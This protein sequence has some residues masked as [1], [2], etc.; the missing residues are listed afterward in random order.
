PRNP[1][2][3]ARQRRESPPSAR[4]VLPPPRTYKLLRRAVRPGGRRPPIPGLS[5]SF[6]TRTGSLENAATSRSRTS[7][8]APSRPP[9]NGCR[10]NPTPDRRHHRLRAT[11]YGHGPATPTYSVIFPEASIQHR[12]TAT[13]TARWNASG[14]LYT[15]KSPAR[16]ATFTAF[17]VSS[18]LFP[19]ATAAFTC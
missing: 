16:P 19:C 7:Q 9:P 6:R 17:F 2:R 5:G 3:L 11:R 12:S 15:A 18:R 1:H 10:P 4:P 8:K 14:V 13:L